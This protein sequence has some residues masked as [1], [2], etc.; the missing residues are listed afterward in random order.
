[1]ECWGV[2]AIAYDSD[3]GF[4]YGAVINLFDYGQGDF[5]PGYK[6]SVFLEWSRTTKGSGINQIEYDSEH[7]IP[8]IRVTGE[9]SYLTEK[10]LDFYGFDGYR[11]PYFKSWEDTISRMYYRLDQNLLRAKTE[12]QGKLPFKNINWLAG[13]SFYGVKVDSVDLDNLNKGKREEDKI[14]I[15]GGGLYGQFIRWGIINEH[16]YQGGNALLLRAGAIYDTRD[17]EANPMKGL[18]TGIQLIYCPEL[19]QVSNQSF[20]KLVINHRQYFTLIPK[21]LNLAVRASY[22]G[23]IWGK[24]PFY[25]LPYVYNSAPSPTRNGLGGAKT[26][27][28]VLRNRVVGED[29][30]YGNLEL[31]YKFYRATYFKQNIYAALAAFYDWG[32]VTSTYDL[33]KDLPQEASGF[34]SAGQQGNRAQCHWAGAVCSHERKFCG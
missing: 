24:Q 17:N 27:R 22:Q 4:K 15:S 5:Y 32:L 31:R 16:E 3:I 25:M 33:P 14:P 20:A 18:W 9:F 23:R 21:H 2:P 13:F 7:L 8:G 34:F 6:H 1:M 10:A 11:T 19:G 29:F 26:V 12:F 30:L 28:G